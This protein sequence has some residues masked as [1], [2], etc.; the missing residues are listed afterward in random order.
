MLWRYADL[1]AI[2]T[3][4]DVVPL[5]DENRALV[6][7]GLQLINQNSREAISALRRVAG[8]ED[9]KITASE[10]A[11]QLSPRINAMGRISDAA[12]AVR[13]LLSE[14]YNEIETL[15][16][17]LTIITLCASS[18][19]WKFLRTLRRSWMLIRALQQAG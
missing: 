12:D 9:K 13:L 6:K 17:A 4:A 11:F 7:F 16:K 1:V 18:L 10:I 8:V 14:D 5:L 2:G 15:A 3:V 19:K